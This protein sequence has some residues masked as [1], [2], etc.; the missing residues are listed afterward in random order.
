VIGCDI[1]DLFIAD[2][3]LEISEN[4]STEQ[5]VTLLTLAQQCKAID[6]IEMMRS[7]IEC[8]TIKH[9]ER[10]TKQLAA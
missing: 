8:A 10:N 3:A 2:V 9:L 1:P 6:V 4:I 5:L 7:L